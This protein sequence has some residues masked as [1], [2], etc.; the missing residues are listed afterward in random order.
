MTLGEKLAKLRKENHYTQEQL[1]DILDVSRQSVSKW[2]SDVA[3]PETEK[4]VKLGKLYHCSM[5]Y[6]LNDEITEEMKQEESQKKEETPSFVYAGDWRQFFFE[7]KS[8][9]TIGGVPLWHIN[10]GFGRIA[11]GIFSVGLVSRGVFSLGIFSLGIFSFGVF[12]LGLLAFGAMASGMFSAG[13]IS[14]G[15]IAAGAIAVGIVAFGALAI[16]QYSVGALAVGNY[17][18]LGDHAYGKIAIYKTE[19]NGSVYMTNSYSQENYS[20]VMRVLDAETPRVF[21]WAKTI[22]GNVLQSVVFW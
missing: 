21:G 14:V 8:K 18:A 5:D 6:L 11:S 20:A 16:G 19:G 13:A 17:F 15:I 3:Y 4:L 10:I 12:A 2:E 22:I 7:R 9:R 1:A